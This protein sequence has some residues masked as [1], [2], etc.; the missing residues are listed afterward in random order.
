MEP[1]E[2]GALLQQGMKCPFTRGY[3]KLIDNGHKEEMSDSTS[4]SRHL[5]IN[6]D[7]WA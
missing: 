1:P 7:T 5:P 2:K 6:H 4:I 3:R